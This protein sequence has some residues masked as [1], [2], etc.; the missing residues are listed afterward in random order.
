MAFDS[1]APAASSPLSNSSPFVST[2]RLAQTGEIRDG[3]CVC[4]CGGVGGVQTGG[5]LMGKGGC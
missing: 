5:M 1:T 3:V 4:V 2:D